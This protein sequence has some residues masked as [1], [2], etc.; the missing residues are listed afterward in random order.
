MNEHSIRDV[1]I[2]GG[3]TAG[4]MAAAAF[5]RFLNN[6]YTKIT[7]IESEEIGTIGVGEATIPPLIAFNSLLGINENEFVS[8]TQATFKLGIEFVNWS[9]I[10]H[11]YFHPF[12]SMGQDLQ[13]VAFHQLYLREA[14]RRQMPPITDWA[15]SAVAAAQGKFA[16]PG[17]AAQFPLN[18]MLYAFHFDAGLYARFLRGFAERGGVRRLEGKVVDVTLRG[19]DGFVESV[20]LA[21]GQVVEGE[22]FIDCSGFRGLLIEQALHTGYEDW[23]HWLPCDRAIAAPCKL[24]PTLDPFTRSTAHTAGWQWRI[25]LQHRMGNGHVYSSAFMS[26]DEAERIL[27]ENLEGE[28]TAD[29]RR[30]SFTTGRRKQSWNKNVV[31]LGLSSGFVEPLESTSIHLIQAG[32]ARLIELFP[33]KRFNPLERDEFNKR[34]EQ[35][36][37]WVRDFIILHYKATERD[38][39]EFWKQCAAME[40]PDKL[41]EK[42]DQFRNKGRVFADGLE[43]FNT[44]SWVAVMLGQHIVPEEYNPVV[45]G[46]DENKIAQALEQMRAGFADIG[47]RLPSQAEFIA[48]CCAAT[49]PPAAREFAL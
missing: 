18:Q 13:G 26:D 28:L 31:A 17:P 46:L 25:P 38:D 4:W 35:G 33:D 16:R 23:T 7:L 45:D 27:V 43:L 30:L 44:V 21:D 41:Q 32:I 19:E 42:I 5:S 47:Q 11:R 3:G 40:I 22:L 49:P 24:P 2:V 8:A 1:V 39:S 14:K 12:G 37:E 20:A 34:L 9:R 10:G 36:Y 6:G 29:P 48:S 15:M